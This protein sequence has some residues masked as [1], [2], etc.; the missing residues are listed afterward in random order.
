MKAGPV[1]LVFNVAGFQA[2]WFSCVAG[3]GH[4]LLWPGLVATVVFAAMMLR[5][6]GHCRQD[7]RALILLLPLGIAIDSALAY[8]GWL[9]YELPLPWSWLAPAW[10]VALWVGF[11]LSLNHSL[12]FLRHRP[13]LAA[14]FGALGG[15]AA[16]AASANVLGAVAFG[17]PSLQAL[18]AVGLAWAVFMP[19]AFSLLGRTA[20]AAPAPK[21]A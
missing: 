18:L 8:S 19:L 7:L 13:W 10:I 1:L 5:F 21:P 11:I 17:V 12:S 2:V 3:A 15:P 14:L 16:Y 20:F 9:V 6:G 4:G